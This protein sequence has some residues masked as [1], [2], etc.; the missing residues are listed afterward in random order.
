MTRITSPPHRL[1]LIL[2]HW[3]ILAAMSAE[4]VAQ[5]SYIDANGEVPK[6]IERTPQ[7]SAFGGEKEDLRLS[8]ENVTWF[9]E[10]CALEGCVEIRRVSF[11]VVV[12]WLNFAGP[13]LA[14]LTN[15]DGRE[16]DNRT[17][18]PDALIVE[19]NDD[20]TLVIA[21][22]N[23]SGNGNTNVHWTGVSNCPERPGPLGTHTVRRPDGTVRKLLT[24][25]FLNAV[26]LEVKN[27]AESC[28]VPTLQVRVDY[29]HTYDDDLHASWSG[30]TGI[31]LTTTSDG[32]VETTI[33]T[34]IHWTNNHAWL[35]SRFFSFDPP[36]GAVTDCAR[37]CDNAPSEDPAAAPCA[38]RPTESECLAC[39]EERSTNEQEFD[40]CAVTCR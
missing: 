10:P 4:L 23:P 34:S 11:L 39:C 25:G 7:Q 16:A 30:E 14:G 32:G 6:G 38:N 12:E 31:G 19:W 8:V 40:A 36:V 17:D 29:L 9:D 33:S 1:A 35:K 20:W 2:G 26:T 27:P 5:N 3:L 24:H 21:T 28:V 13:W 37:C 18:G 22:G 15:L